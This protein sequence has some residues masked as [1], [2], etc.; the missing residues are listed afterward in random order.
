M[1]KKNKLTFFKWEE[2]K[3]IFF[4]KKFDNVILFSQPR[5]GSTFVSNVLS[6]ELNFTE[7]FFPEEFFLNQHFVYLKTFI[8]KNNNFFININEYW[9]RRPDLKKNNTMYLYLYRDIQ[10]ILNSYKKAKKLNYYMGWEEMIDRYRRFFPEIKNIEPAPLFGHKV[11]ENQI[12]NFDNAYT[13]LYESFKTH[14]FYLDQDMRRDKIK[15]LKDIE[16][17]ENINIKKKFI[18]KMGGNIPHSEKMKIRFNLFE[19]IYFFIRRKLENR[20]KNR[21]NY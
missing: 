15:N 5:S 8:K 10:E 17:I 11:W 16:L 12:K 18:D 13:V 14:K 3:E 7:N 21:K 20:K 6:K 4:D 9:V 2:I 19:N 1:N